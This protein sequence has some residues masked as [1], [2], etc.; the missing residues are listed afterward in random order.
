MH[1]VL[2]EQQEYDNDGHDAHGCTG[3]KNCPVGVPFLEVF[4]TYRQGQFVII[5]D[6]DH[7][8]EECVPNAAERQNCRCSN[9]RLCVGKYDLEE[10]T[11]SGTAIH[12]R[13]IFKILGDAQEIL[14]EEKDVE[15]VRSGKHTGKEQCGIGVRQMRI[16]NDFVV[17]DKRYMVGTIMVATNARN[18]MFLPLNSNRVSA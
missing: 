1:E 12:D 18:K 13:C 5:V 15:C 6:Y 8:P 16:H 11:Q 17:R 10:H 2:L 7:R 14:P 4:K 9:G 3:Q